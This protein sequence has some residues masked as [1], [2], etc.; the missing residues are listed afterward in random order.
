MKRFLLLSAMLLSLS[1]TAL[2]DN[3]P[4]PFPVMIGGQT[5]HRVDGNLTHAIIDK[6]VTANAPMAVSGQSGQV[7]ANIFVSNAQGQPQS[8]SSQPLIL[9]FSAKENK[10]ISDNMS[11][12]APKPGWYLA[13]VVAGGATSR[14]VFQVK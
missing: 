2:A 5:A 11:H 14:V 1:L 7:I 6:P 12:T 13:N 4:L 9:I 8:G 10:P 3:D